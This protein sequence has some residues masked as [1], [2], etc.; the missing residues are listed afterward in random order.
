[1]DTSGKRKAT[2]KDDILISAG[3]GNML[4]EDWVDNV[5]YEQIKLYIWDEDLCE[6]RKMLLDKMWGLK[7]NYLLFLF[8]YLF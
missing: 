6:Y 3:K 1:M 2:W 4:L 5:N 7:T 8:L